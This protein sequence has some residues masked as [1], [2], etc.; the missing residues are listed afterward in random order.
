MNCYLFPK[1]SKFNDFNLFFVLAPFRCLANFG[2]SSSQDSSVG[3][4]LDLVLRRSGVQFQPSPIEFSNEE[5]LQERFFAV[6]QKKYCCVESNL[7]CVM[8]NKDQQ[9]PPNFGSLKV[10][11]NKS[12]RVKRSLV[13]LLGL[14]KAVTKMVI[15]CHRRI[16]VAI[17]AF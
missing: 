15:G 10:E 11:N 16:K 4:A 17:S 12:L 3:S 14:V 13:K 2:K 1:Q 8:I 5:R 7:K 6:C 9:I